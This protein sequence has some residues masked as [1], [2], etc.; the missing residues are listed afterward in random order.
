MGRPRKKKAQS[1]NLQSSVNAW[2]STRYLFCLPKSSLRNWTGNGSLCR[3]PVRTR[4][5]HLHFGGIA[6]SSLLVVDRPKL[7]LL[8]FAGAWCWQCKGMSNGL[9]CYAQTQWPGLLV[10]HTD[11]D[12]KRLTSRAKGVIGWKSNFCFSLCMSL[13]MQ[14]Y[15]QWVVLLCENAQRSQ[16]TR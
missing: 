8:L 16:L 11:N 1:N 10:N 4:K 7:P 2:H 15:V 6:S 13:V 3:T 14:G 5:S 9:L 12:F